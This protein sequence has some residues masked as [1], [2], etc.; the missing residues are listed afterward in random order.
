MP[1]LA[2]TQQLV[3]AAL[4]DRTRNADALPLIDGDR[5]RERLEIYRN[6]VMANA[7]LALGAIYPIVHKLVGAEFFK[8]LAHAYCGA[9]PS[10]SGDLNEMGG[11]L[12]DFVQTFPPAKPLPYLPDVARLEW[13]AHKA[14]YAADHAPLDAENL[15]SIREIDYLRLAVTLHPA[16]AVLVSEF[17]IHRIWEVHQDDYHG[18]IAVELG[19]GGEGILVY[20]P[21][22]RVAVAKLS[23]GESA[24]LQS[25]TRG[26]LLGPALEH[27]LAAD[28]RFDL[29]ASLQH[30][31]VEN[32][33][34]G[35]EVGV[36]A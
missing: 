19:S 20:R 6:N 1:D 15:A 30:W 36:Q 16:A 25:V 24:F 2:A 17:P 34:V 32:I 10:T 18:E 11:A 4:R 31:T 33:V 7:S 35:L 29:T 3:S 23:R 28:A 12:A 27:A 13:L 14:H 21:Q 9:H 5:A 26:V 8:G 22:F